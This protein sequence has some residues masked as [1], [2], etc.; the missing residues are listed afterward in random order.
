MRIVDFKF[1][2][3]AQWHPLQLAGY[4][5]LD[6]QPK[7]RVDMTEDHIYY[8]DGIQRPSV[9]S[10]IGLPNTAKNFYTPLPAKRGGWLHDALAII[11][12][13]KKKGEEPA[14]DGQDTELKATYQLYLD[15][16]ADRARKCDPSQ[17]T[18]EKMG[19]SEKH[20]F[21]GTP[22]LVIDDGKIKTVGECVY[23]DVKAMK[24]KAKSWDIDRKLIK[25]F[26]AHRL[27]YRYWKKI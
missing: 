5:L 1:G 9:S 17:W 13:M 3:P 21:A 27:V 25:I 10:I 15:Y 2:K 22:D 8:V 4:S 14:M 23:F 16:W 6:M 11:G 20:Q 7:Q 18:I 19:Y 26:L 24:I 12:K